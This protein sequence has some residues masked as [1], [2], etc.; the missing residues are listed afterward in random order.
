M[1]RFNISLD[2]SINFVLF[3]IKNMIGGEIFVP[4]ILSYNVL[5]VA[6]SID[7]KEKLK[8]LVL[9]LEKKFTKK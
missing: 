5:D 8:L 2:E 4:K 3:S 6:K 1:T 7:E 9:D